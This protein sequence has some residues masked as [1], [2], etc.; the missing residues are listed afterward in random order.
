MTLKIAIA[1]ATAGRRD[2]LSKTVGH[3]FEQT[4]IADEL[5]ICPA[6]RHDFDPACL[7]RYPG[8]SDVFHGPVGTSSQRNVLIDASMADVMIF[9]DDDFLPCN[10][11][12]A[13][14]EALFASRPD[15]VM[16]TGKLLADD[17]GGPGLT[18]E[19]GMR[20]LESAGP[21][22]ASVSTT[23]IYNGYGC[24]MAVRLRPVRG[25]RIRFDEHLPLYAW[26]ED[27]DF[28]RQ[29]VPYGDI[30]RSP[31]LRGVHLGTKGA[32]RSSGVRLGY[33]QI[34]NPVYLARKG[35]MHWPLARSHMARNLAAN[36]AR[37]FAPEAWVDRRGR[38]RGNVVALWDWVRGRI[39]P[40]RVIDF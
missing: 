22:C 24:N 35:T 27:L 32:S 14:V 3:L 29:L 11:Y 21:N 4:R 18:P 16:A 23:A 19:Q 7:V 37:S 39:D 26:L 36:S 25:H 15:V 2:V 33:S 34:A 10:D 5:L 38:L 9:F 6:K 1:I 13:E 12:V 20:I 8:H 28:S 40:Q 17:I 30:V 31:R